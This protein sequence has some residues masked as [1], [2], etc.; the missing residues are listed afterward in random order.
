MHA[1]DEEDF[2]WNDESEP[3]AKYTPEEFYE[4]LA[5]HEVDYEDREI[6]VKL[7]FNK[8]NINIIE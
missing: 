3:F 8:I 5:E 2:S 4:V 6:P 1:Y 7:I